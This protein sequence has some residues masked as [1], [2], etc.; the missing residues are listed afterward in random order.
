MESRLPNAP[1]NENALASN[2]WHRLKK[3]FGE[4]KD[5]NP[6]DIIFVA[7]DLESVEQR[8]K[9]VKNPIEVVCEVGFATL[10]MRD[11]MGSKPAPTFAYVEHLVSKVKNKYVRVEEHR[12]KGAKDFRYS[13][14]RPGTFKY[15]DRKAEWQV[16][17]SI[18]QCSALT[19]IYE[20]SQRAQS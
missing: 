3:Y 15:G 13:K 6:Q 10:D 8:E 19:N 16:S 18:P 20:G 4:F 2:Q 12:D 7:F 14:V 9:G 5:E 11:M 17:A 1:H